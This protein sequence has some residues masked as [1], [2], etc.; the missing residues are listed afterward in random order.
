MCKTGDFVVFLLK[1]FKMMIDRLKR[2]C[3]NESQ[4]I[5][6]ILSKGVMVQMFYIFIYK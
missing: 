1:F 5:V 4:K 2:N 3:G 6:V